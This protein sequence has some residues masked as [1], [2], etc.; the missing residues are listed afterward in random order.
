M[1][2][3]M[4]Q[5]S[6]AVLNYNGKDYL[7]ETFDSINV[8]DYPAKELLM[9]DDGS[10]DGSIEFVRGNYPNVR[11]IE[12]GSNTKMLNKVRNRALR[13]AGSDYVLITDNDIAFAPDCLSILV[14]KMMS[15]RDVAVLTPRVMYE[16]NKRRIYIDHNEFHY[17]CA[18]IDKYRD[19]GLQEIIQSGEPSVTFGCGIMLIDKAKIRRR[20]LGFFDEDYPMGWGDDGEFHHRV[21]LSGLRCYA[22]PQAMVYHKAIRGAP[23]IYGQLLNR[24]SM[25]IETYAW[26]TVVV[27]GPALILYECVLLAGIILK[28][29]GREYLR[30]V[31]TLIRNLPILLKKRKQVFEYKTE[32]DR[33]LLTSGQ[34]YAPASFLSYSLVRIGWTIVNI[35]LNGYWHI[36]RRFI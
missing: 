4:K 3:E 1:L 27:F 34:I 32:Q 16:E 14:G 25:I 17:V 5:I 26:R 23:R 36:A 24:W 19:K 31:M 33:H 8:L 7:E 12:M 11:I 15:L 9:V 28:G 6:I 20:G 22:I 29:R 18:S 35:A 2:E 10:T 21:N 13:E 30:A